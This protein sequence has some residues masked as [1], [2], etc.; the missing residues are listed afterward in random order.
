M[1]ERYEVYHGVKIHDSAL[2]AAATLSDRYISDRFLP[3]KA[4]DLVDEACALIKTEMNSM[5]S[6][7]DEISREIMRLEIEETAL[8]GDND[9]HTQEHLAEIRRELA[10]KRDKFNNMKARWDNERNAISKVQQLRERIEQVNADIA[11]AENEYDL[12]RAAQ[13]KYGELPGLQKELQKEEALA[14]NRENSLLRD[15]VSSE[16]IAKIVARWTGIP[17]SKLMESERKKLLRLDSQLH[18]RIVGQDDAVQRVCDAILRS[19]A[20]IQNPNRPIGSFLFLGPTGVGKTELCKALAEALFDDERSMVRIDMSEYME[21]YS[22]SRLIGAPPGYV[23]YDEGG[24]L[25]EAVR[26]KPYAV[27]LFDEVEKAH[28][29]VLN[30]LLQVLD[31]GRITDGQGRTVDFKNTII[32]LTSNIGSDLILSSMAK[33]GRITTETEEL[34]HKLLRTKFRPEFINRLDEIVFF[35]ALSDAD[36]H[37]IVD[38]LIADLAKRLQ[39]NRLNL[40]VSESAK[41][42]I[43]KNGA[44]PLFG[45]RPLKRY[46][47]GHIESLLARFIIENSPEEGSTL[48]VDADEKGSFIIGQKQ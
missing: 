29:D 47:Q 15:H 6:E 44:D 34:L 23:G 40:S 10:E 7:M 21:Q 41:A 4:I 32:I 12:N 2:I 9:E 48:T 13:L 19:R 31:D 1:K 38:L 16:E 18:K 43:I 37:G 22:V 36:M 35:N 8:T 42:A 14:A 33:D 17:V 24:Q 11:R 5:P 30:V 45:A 28:P 27:L 20:G 25:T 46:I 39:A 3:D 26:R